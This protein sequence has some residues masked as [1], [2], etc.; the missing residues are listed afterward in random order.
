[1]KT[2]VLSLAVAAL[3]LSLVSSA[4]GEATAPTLPKACKLLKRSEAQT[5]AGMRLQP[6][7]D[8]GQKCAYNSYP[9]DTVGQVFIVIEPKVPPTLLID[10]KLG[11]K[12]WKVKGIGDVA[13]EEDWKIFVRKGK[14]WVEI[15]LVRIDSFAAYRKR[16]EQAA[17][18]AISRVKVAPKRTAA[19]SAKH[20]PAVGG[21]E[22]WTGAE[23]RFGD[24]ITNY[25]GVTYQPGVVLI[26]GGAHAVRG[27]S[28]DGLTWTIAGNAPGVADLRVGKI[29]LATTFAAG[30]VLKLTR[31]GHNLRVVLGPVQLTDV[32]RDAVF[33][34]PQPVRIANP[35]VYRTKIAKPKKRHAQ[36]VG[37]TAVKANPLCCDASLGVHVED[38]G[39]GGQ[40]SAKVGFYVKRP[41]VDFRIEI[42]GGK[43]IEAA[44]ELS[45]VGGLRYG[46][47]AATMSSSQ[48]IY[49]EPQLVPDSITIPLAGPLALTLNQSFIVSTYLMGQA[50]LA[51]YADYSARGSFAFGYLNGG[52]EAG[53]L[54]F[55]VAAPL[56]HNTASVGVGVNKIT[57]G[58]RLRATVGLGLAGFS[59]GAWYTLASGISAVADGTHGQSLKFGCVSAAL[60]I[61]QGFG[62]GF[63]MPEFVRR[64]VNT[65]LSAL[66]VRPVPE[67]LGPS[68]GPFEIVKTEPV[69][70]CPQRDGKGP[71]RTIAGS[72]AKAPADMVL[73]KADF[74]RTAKANRT[75]EY[76]EKKSHLVTYR[77]RSGQKQ[78][79]LSSLVAVLPRVKLA[80]RAYR[81]LKSSVIGIED[82]L[83]LPKYGD[84]QDAAYLPATDGQLVVR[85][86]NT[87]W[88]LMIGNVVG[89]KPLTTAEATAELLRFAPK[90]MKR[91][92]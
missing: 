48:N 54:K 85:K 4:S 23:R 17:R 67:T 33:E 69:K 34:S 46:L 5:L 42:R 52:A 88:A 3:A 32:F 47:R 14:L 35:L 77:Y 18:I 37:V 9:T 31:V 1:M 58:W 15:S 60:A 13:W 55:R 25:A 82:K 16:L 11:H 74:P 72:S 68:W 56:T 29:M 76:P 45:G 22:R 61:N 89:T 21:R 51:A 78:V 92:G 36:Q 28:L 90:A 10:R 70:Y 24:G 71:S 91:V 26:G 41:S 43:L 81:E 19:N 75:D 66:R 53:K 87:V 2:L 7:I 50:A 30:R 44:M 80:K 27:R 62:I 39:P 63:T 12:F 6:A 86:G 38:N 8:A 59:A 57:V 64:I 79:V 84:E 73:Q 65:I 83:T 20:P 49:S 40:L